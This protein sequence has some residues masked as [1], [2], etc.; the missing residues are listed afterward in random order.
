MNISVNCILYPD[1]KEH[2]IM[3]ATVQKLIGTAMLG[4]TLFSHSLP[5]WAGVAVRKEVYISPDGTNVQGSLTG[6][7]YSADNQQFI[8]CEHY[9]YS[10]DKPLLFCHARDKSG[11]SVLCGSSDPRITDAVKGM[12]DSSYLIFSISSPSTGSICTDLTISNES[13]YLP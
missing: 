12:T 10:G 9:Y 4:L 2:D 11:K 1:R 13:I 5:A 3:K 7:R 6:A 8:D